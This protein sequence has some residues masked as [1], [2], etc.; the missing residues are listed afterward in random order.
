MTDHDTYVYLSAALDQ[1]ACKATLVAALTS[2]V[3]E[4]QQRGVALTAIVNQ[5]Q[6]IAAEPYQMNDDIIALVLDELTV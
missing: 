1:N 3:D 6:Q 2:R 4:L 5:L